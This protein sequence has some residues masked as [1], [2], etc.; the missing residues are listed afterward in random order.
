[1]SGIDGF[2]AICAAVRP[3]ASFLHTTRVTVRTRQWNGGEIGTGAYADDDFTLGQEVRVSKLT[4]KE[5]GTSGGFFT[6]NDVK[7]THITPAFPGGGYTLQQVAPSTQ[8]APAVLEATGYADALGYSDP[9]PT[10]EY[11]Y[12]LFGDINGIYRLKNCN[13][14]HALHYTLYLEEIEVHASSNAR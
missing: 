6:F 7:V 13:D 4:Q 14:D 10:F 8:M 2:R 5:I 11:I 1:M 3:I 12:I 9:Q